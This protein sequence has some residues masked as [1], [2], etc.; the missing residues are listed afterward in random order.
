MFGPHCAPCSEYAPD[1]PV[2]PG[3]VVFRSVSPGPGH[4]ENMLLHSGVLI[5]TGNQV[6]HWWRAVT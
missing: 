3:D 1:E 2:G 5:S 6:S 4:Y